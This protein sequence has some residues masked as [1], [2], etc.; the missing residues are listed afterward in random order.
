MPPRLAADR[1]RRE[2]WRLHKNVAYNKV[3]KL[4]LSALYHRFNDRLQGRIDFRMSF[5][6]IVDGMNVRGFHK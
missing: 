2:A 6:K 4:I 5:H 1:I 3:E